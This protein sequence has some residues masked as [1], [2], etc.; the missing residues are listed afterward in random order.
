MN[1]YQS[2]LSKPTK[3]MVTTV[4]P[5]NHKLRLP[6]KLWLDYHEPETMNYDGI[7]NKIDEILP[8]HQKIVAFSGGKDSGVVLKK[9]LD[10]ELVERAFFIRTNI[11]SKITEDFCID[12]CKSYGI[13]IDIREPVPH[14][15]IYIALCLELGFPSYKTHGL[16]M[17]V[18]KYQTMFKYVTEPQFKKRKAVLMSGVR[19]YES[20]RRKFNYNQPINVD[21]NKLWFCCPIF[22][23]TNEDVYRYYVES[24]LKKSP[25][26][27]WAGTSLECACGSFSAQRD[28]ELV[29]KNDPELFKK[30]MWIKQGI[31]WFGHDYAKERSNWGN[32]K[33]ESDDKIQQ[34]MTKFLGENVQH[35]SDV[36]QMVCGTECGAGTMRDVVDF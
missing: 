1:H 9:L 8:N 31:E 20:E 27:D 15:F 26:Y 25:V 19:K 28:L 3:E 17:R 34:I 24:N 32:S 22:Y 2:K 4:W 5:K 6:K 7:L 13:P 16:L 33:P 11:G 29:K 14:A 18:L 30:I 23:E 36:S 35:A 21:S 12:T 10:K